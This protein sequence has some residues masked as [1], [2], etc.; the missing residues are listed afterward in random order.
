[1]SPAFPFGEFRVY[2]L[3]AADE[4]GVACVGVAGGGEHGAHGS[5]SGDW[6]TRVRHVANARH[7]VPCEP[8]SRVTDR[9]VSAREDYRLAD[10]AARA[11]SR[12]DEIELRQRANGARR[13]VRPEH[14]EAVGAFHEFHGR[15][16]AWV[17]FDGVWDAGA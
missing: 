4:L 10:S 8:R 6:F 13:R 5:T 1:M 3:G 14:R 12:P 7:S 16:P 9:D 2:A 17:H 11:A 15:G